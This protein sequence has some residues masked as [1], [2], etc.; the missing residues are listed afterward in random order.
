MLARNQLA[1]A[2]HPQDLLGLLLHRI[3][4]LIIVAGCGIGS[5]CPL[6]CALSAD[7]RS[8]PNIVL[9]LADDLGYG[10][11]GCYGQTKIRTPNV[12][13]LAAEGMRFTAM[14]AGCNV[15]APS[16]CVLM[17]GRHPGHA[18]IRNNRGGVGQDGKRTEGQE[19]VP[20]GDRGSASG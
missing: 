6:K 10:D 16:R 18:Y 7:N 12:D 8:V 2:L 9:I 4:T 20:P 1:A 15:C 3:T 11:L 19:P 14:Y 13:R 5:I 17:S